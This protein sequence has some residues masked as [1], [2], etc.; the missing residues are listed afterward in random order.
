MSTWLLG[1]SSVWMISSEYLCVIQRSSH[2]ITIPIFPSH[3]P[4]PQNSLY[5][6]SYSALPGHWATAHESKNSNLRLRFLPYKIDGQMYPF[7][8]THWKIISPIFIQPLSIS[9]FH[10]HT[11]EE[12]YSPP[13]AVCMRILPQCGYWF[14]PWWDIGTT[15]MG[16]T[17]IWATCSCS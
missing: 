9:R 10:P 12:L 16:D 3:R 15:L 6:I 4:L 17:G 5:L 8:S 2:F 14:K 11:E 1:A 13:S 7:G